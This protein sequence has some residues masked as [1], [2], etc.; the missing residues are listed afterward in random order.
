[1]SEAGG[2]GFDIGRVVN[3]IFTLI[4]RNLVPFVLLSLLAV[5]ADSARNYFMS[6][7]LLLKPEYALTLDYWLILL[8]SEIVTIS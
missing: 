7:Q 8:A 2:A 3:R 1:M 6:H 5:L 4:G